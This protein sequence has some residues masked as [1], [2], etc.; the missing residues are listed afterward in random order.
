MKLGA[1]RL[2]AEARGEE[3]VARRRRRAPARRCRSA[4]GRRST[5]RAR[6][7]AR[8]ARARSGGGSGGSSS[9]VP[10]I[11][12]CMSRCTSSSSS[13]TRYLPRRPSALDRGGPRRAARP[14]RAPAARTSAGRGSRSAREHAALDAR[15]EL[16]ADRLDLGQLGHRAQASGSDVGRRAAIGP[17]RARGFA[18]RGRLTERRARAAPGASRPASQRSDARADVGQ[19]RRRGAPPWPVERRRAAARARACGR[20]RPRPGRRRGRR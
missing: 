20:C 6:R 5:A 8:S 2:D 11:R 13:Q 7:R 17:A 1:E 18:E 19:R 14:P 10:V 3:R 9:S 4:A 15:R 12:R 16:A